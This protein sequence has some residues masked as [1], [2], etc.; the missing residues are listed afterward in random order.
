MDLLAHSAK[1]VKN[2]P[3][4]HFSGLPAP[5]DER[6]KI[7]EILNW[8]FNSFVQYWL[9]EE[10]IY[11]H[12]RRWQL[13]WKADRNTRCHNSNT[14]YIT[15]ESLRSVAVLVTGTRYW[16]CGT[17]CDG[18]SGS[19]C[20]RW[21]YSQNRQSQVDKYAENRR[22]LWNSKPLSFCFTTTEVCNFQRFACIFWFWLV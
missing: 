13:L 19:C 17:I 11:F 21:P 22:Q 2:T 14:Y 5:P 7:S 16:L 8:T 18:P 10:E 9:A 6:K 1:L 4:C 15:V 3:F 12:T 20:C